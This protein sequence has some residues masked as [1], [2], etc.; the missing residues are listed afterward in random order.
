MTKKEN[1]RCP[2]C[3]NTNLRP[4]GWNTKRT[5]RR[6]KCI[7]CKR[8]L[9]L[10]GKN[11]FV[12]DAQIELV[13]ALLL[14][15]ISLRGICRAIKISLSWLMKYMVR[16]YDRQPDGLNYRMPEKAE[17]DLQLIDCE[18][19]ELWSFVH[20]KKNKQWVW[21]AQCRTTRQVIA[22]QVGGR[23]RADAEKL[24]DKIPERLKKEGFFYSDD[25]DAYK[26]V[27]PS[28]RHK[29]SKNKKDTN[30][31]ERLNN[32]IRQRVS[33]LV[34]KSLSFSKKLENHIYAIKYFFCNYNLEQQE[35]WD[36]YKY[37]SAHL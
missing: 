33:R 17:I 26:G 19:D 34:R 7:D 2:Y 1:E 22:F 8:H 6:K 16:L 37:K 35:K 23:G 10:E 3:L 15:R 9:V 27:F 14:E 21:I 18:L 24:W 30:H 32:T 5:K 29:S 11:W 13:D 25:W 20:R 28:Q 31:L 36:K 12:S 4:K